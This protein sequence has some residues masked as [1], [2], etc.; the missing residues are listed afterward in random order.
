MYAVFATCLIKFLMGFP[1]STWHDYSILI[2]MDV[3][4]SK[5]YQSVP[6]QNVPNIQ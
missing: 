5:D 2:I 6:Y 4:I 3:Y 1:P